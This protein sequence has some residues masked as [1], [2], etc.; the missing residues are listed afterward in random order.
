MQRILLKLSLLAFTVF[1][2]SR[3]SAAVR[4]EGGGNPSPLAE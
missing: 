4:T 2:I 3:S 1:A